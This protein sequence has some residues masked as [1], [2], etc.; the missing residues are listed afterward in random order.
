M[1][2]RQEKDGNAVGE[3]R[4]DAGEGVL[5]ARAILHQ[6]DARGFPFVT[7]A[8]P[9]AMSTPTRSCRQMIGRMPAATAFS[10][11]GV[12][13]KQKRV[14]MPSRLRISTIASPVRTGISP[15]YQGTQPR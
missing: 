3:R 13:G 9:S 5:G 1:G 14:D 6:E 15:L 7:R 2:E 11:R 10:I 4:C 12:V 8:K